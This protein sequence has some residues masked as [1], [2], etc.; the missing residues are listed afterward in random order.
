MTNTKRSRLI[1]FIALILPLLFVFV[2][3][4]E[5]LFYDYNYDTARLENFYEEEKGSLDVILIGASEV[6]HG[7]VPGYAYEKYGY[8]SY[9]YSV[10]SN[11]GSLYLT[12]LKEILKHQ[13]PEILIV[14]LSGFLVDNDPHFFNSII[15]Q[16]YARGIP[17]S[18]NKLQ[19]KLQYQSDQTLSFLFPLIMYHGHPSVAYAR[20]SAL[21]ADLT[22]EAKEDPLKGALTVTRIY[23]SIG[24]EGKNTNDITDNVR[25]YLVDFITY[26]RDNNLDNVIFTNFPRKILDE[27][28]YH[29]LYLLGQL[30]QII[31]QYGYP[32]WNLQDDLDNIGIDKEQDF[33]DAYHLNIYGAL[34]LT[35]YFGEKLTNEYGLSPRTQSDANRLE[36]EECVS[37]TQEYIQ[38]AKD[39]IQ[40]GNVAMLHEI[41]DI[42]LYR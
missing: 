20:L 26:C 2:F 23:P 17:F 28:D 35:D 21:Y 27:S 16:N 14:D 10:D 22:K 5:F 34:K 3:A 9:N 39:M 40:A 32:V 11:M 31:E 1:K 6:T 13:S 8:T 19:M 15:L 25:A 24:D 12:Q 37:N 41:A 42:W 38:M 30:E 4:Q 18:K 7:Y 29:L 36:W 33:S